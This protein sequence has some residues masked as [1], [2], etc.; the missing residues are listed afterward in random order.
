MA[1][2][3]F[4]PKLSSTMSVGTILQW[5]KEVGESVEVGEPL[6]EIMTDKINIEVESSEEGVL[7]AKY[8]DIDEQ[9]PVNQVIGYIGQQGEP[10]PTKYKVLQQDGEQNGPTALTP[11]H[12]KTPSEKVTSLKGKK[13]SPL[14]QKI[15]NSKGIELSTIQGTGHHQKI[16]K[17]DVVAPAPISTPTPETNSKEKLT[18]MRKTIAQR[19]ATSAFTAP[20]VTLNTEVDMTEIKALRS[21]IL[22]PVEQQTGTRISYTDMLVKLVAKTLQR[23]PKLNATF[24]NEEITY[25]GEANI[26]VAVAVEGGLVVPIIK[27]VNALGLVEI[28][29]ASKDIIHRAKHRQ[30]TM[31]DFHGGT[32]TISNLGNYDI[33]TFTPIINAPEVA[34]LGVGKIK[35]KPVVIDQSI[36]IRPMMG[37]SL[38]FDHRVMDGAPAAAFLTDLKKI[39]ESP[40]ELLL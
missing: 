16:M 31:D 22:V 15:A 20:H 13:V 29:H 28:T 35:D 2:E 12:D 3:I 23:H 33:D 37:L 26:G 1:K 40:Y 14:A 24:E 10:I 38:S 34:I 17:K 8:Y 4:M 5:H 21:R 36:E 19:M 11:D 18:G 6:F 25:H 32:F 7:I 9:I 30:L 27:D 39:I